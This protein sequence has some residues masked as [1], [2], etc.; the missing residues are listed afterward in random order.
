M[1]PFLISQLA[2]LGAR[3]ILENTPPGVNIGNPVTATD[4]DD[5]GANNNDIEF[6]DTLT[7]SLSGT[8][9]ASFDIDAST[10]QLITKAPLDF[11]NPTGGT[12]N[13]NVAYEVTV[14]VKDSS[15]ASDTQNVTI[16]V[17]NEEEEPGALAEPTVVSTDSDGDAT[18]YELKVIWYSPD[19]PGDGSTT[20]GVEYKKTTDTSFRTTGVGATSGTTVLSVNIIGLEVDTSYQV[21]VQGHEHCRALVPGRFR[22]WGRPTRR[23]TPCPRSEIPLPRGTFWRTLI[24]GSSSASR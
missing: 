23:T 7:Y 5:D 17:T 22:V 13:N 6:G 3:T 12:G 4:D 15:G 18:T 19:D 2:R 11:E 16:T 24:R 14:T 1:R 10:G 9:E 21:R 20:Y 8:D